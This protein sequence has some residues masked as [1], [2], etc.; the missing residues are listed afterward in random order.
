MDWLIDLVRK[1]YKPD[2]TMPIKTVTD[3]P[4]KDSIKIIQDIFP[5]TLTQKFTDKNSHE[6]MSQ[7]NVILYG[8]PGTGKTYTTIEKAIEIANPKF[9]LKAANGD[10]LP[11]ADIRAE[12]ERLRKAEQ[13]HFVT[14]HQ[15]LTYEDFIEGI[16]PDVN[17]TSLTYSVEPGIFKNICKTAQQTGEVSFKSAY[18]KL[19][20]A[21]DENDDSIVLKTLTHKRDFTIYRNSK[22]NLRFHANTEKAYEGVIRKEIIES[23]LETGV[24]EDWPSYT[25]SVAEY[26][27]SNCG[28]RQ[29]SAT[30]K[31]N[32]VLIID[33]INRGNIS[34]IFGEL[35]TLIEDDKRIG[36]AEALEIMLP[37][38]KK[39]FGV[40]ANLYIIGTMNT[41]D[42]SVEALDTALRRRFSFIEMPPKENHKHVSEAVSISGTQFNFR[43]ILKTINKRLEKLLG[44]DH[45]IGHSFF[46]DTDKNKNWQFYLS[47]FTV[48]II[49]LMQEYFYGDYAKMCL[50]V[51]TGFVFESNNDIED[52]FFAATE[53]N[54]L[55]EISE[56]RVWQIRQFDLD[57]PDAEDA[58]ANALSTLLNK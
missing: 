53:Y 29:I 21:I 38:S 52:N 10:D 31:K 9:K 39:H 43:E 18:D 58:F 1:P 56:K 27:K 49:P 26:L 7:L 3:I 45:K 33:E 34:Q 19:L 11:R 6:T 14:F 57:S 50:V 36:K 48:K 44:R 24:A 47:A 41:A 25:K 12:F 30:D 4:Y 32:Y 22:D 20:Q 40:P 5:G 16:K 23:Y 17:G 15:S 8:P 46:I 55:Q 13:I 28:Y 2:F 42:R 35:I 54:G 37:Y 51:G